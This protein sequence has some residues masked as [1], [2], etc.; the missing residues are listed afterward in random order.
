MGRRN[1]ERIARIEAGQE[2]SI[3]SKVKKGLVDNPLSRRAIAVASRKVVIEE[4]SKGSTEDQVGKLNTLVGAGNLSKGKLKEAIMKKAPEEMDKAIKNFKKVGK[5]V[6]V[7]SLCAEVRSDTSFLN[8]CNQVGLE[9][10]WFENLA[11]E[12]MEANGL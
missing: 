6:T 11:K 12:R 1:R 5:P 2:E 10:S 8:M 4:L 9:L 3:A 7:D